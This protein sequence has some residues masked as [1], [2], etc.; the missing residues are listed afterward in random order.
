MFAQELI[1]RRGQVVTENYAKVRGQFDASRSHL[2]GVCIRVCGVHPWSY[3]GE[4]ID[5][6]GA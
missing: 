1:E 6:F 5:G 3:E 2:V 4:G